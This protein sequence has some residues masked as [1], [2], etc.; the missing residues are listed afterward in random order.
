MLVLVAVA[1]IALDLPV[2]LVGPPTTGA[3][4]PY[5]GIALQVCVDVSVL[6]LA[7]A[8]RMVALFALAAALLM[9]GSDLF[10]PGLLVPADPI[11]LATVPSATPF[12]AYAL[13]KYADRRQA[14][15]IVGAL[16][17]LAAQPWAPSWSTTPFGVLNTAVPALLALYLRA[18]AELL[19]SLRDRAERAE[20]EQHL[21]AQQARADERRRLATEMHDAV[22]HEV[23]MIVLQAGALRV[24]TTDPESRAAAET[25]RTSGTRAIEELRDIIGLLRD[26]PTAQLRHRLDTTGDS[27]HGAGD[28]RPD[29]ATLVAE[30][31]A[32]GHPVDLVVDG[33]PAPVS[34]V[35][36]RTGYRVVQEALTNARKHAPG[37][38]T[39]VDLRYRDDG[40]LIEVRNAAATRA[41][42]PDLA[43]SGSGSGLDGLRQRVELVGGAL[44]A[45]AA[46]DGGYQVSAILPAQPPTADPDGQET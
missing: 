23:S 1:F 41:P 27:G 6:L 7:R 4:G 38:G 17:L 22:T 16:T 14:L 26:D 20:R 13:T 33:D 43:G 32:A 30:S 36:A 11:V 21:R 15:A 46:A 44:R 9:L 40:M 29:P 8:P 25:I 24:T 10:A 34:P 2:G 3:A 12:I 37:G 18:R 39:T 5:A 19:S 45:A 28:R 42:D 35:V 31:R